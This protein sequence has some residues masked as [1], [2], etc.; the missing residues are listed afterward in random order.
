[1]DLLAVVFGVL[2]LA[3][4]MV[5]S[6][7]GE[8]GRTASRKRT[9]VWLLLVKSVMRMGFPSLPRDGFPSWGC[10]LKRIVMR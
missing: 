8:R 6:L 2:M 3:G 10:S 7:F 9:P 5:F 1:M 4:W